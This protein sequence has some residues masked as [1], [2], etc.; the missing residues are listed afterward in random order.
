MEKSEVL[1]TAFTPE[2]PAADDFGKG[3]TIDDLRFDAAFE[4]FARAFTEQ[5]VESNRWIEDHK[6]EMK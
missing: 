1:Y 6:D 4:A 2:F 3:R 5:C